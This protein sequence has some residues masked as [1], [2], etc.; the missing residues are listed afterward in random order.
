[1]LVDF[2]VDLLYVL[3]GGAPRAVLH[4][5]PRGRVRLCCHFPRPDQ[6]RVRGER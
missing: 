1:M 2:I 5:H 3:S 4:P 6:Q